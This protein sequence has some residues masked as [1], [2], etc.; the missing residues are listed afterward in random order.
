MYNFLTDVLGISEDY[1]NG[2]IC[3]G[4]YNEETFIRVLEYTQGYHS[5]EQFIE[6]ELSEEE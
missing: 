1:I 5:F 3:V 6:C 2:A 4:G